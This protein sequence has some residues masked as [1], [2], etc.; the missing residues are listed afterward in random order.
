MASVDMRTVGW[1]AMQKARR[2]ILGRYYNVVESVERANGKH[3]DYYYWLGMAEGLKIANS[4][5]MDVRRVAKE[6]GRG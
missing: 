5:L 6:A 2:L 3:A 1:R 4:I